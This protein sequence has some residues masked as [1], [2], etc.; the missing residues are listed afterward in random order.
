MQTKLLSKNQVNFDLRYLH[1][2]E[3]HEPIAQYS[4]YPV[5]D[6]HC[7][8]CTT[9]FTRHYLRLTTCQAHVLH[10]KFQT[11]N[12][13]QIQM[14]NRTIHEKMSCLYCFRNEWKHFCTNHVIHSI[15]FNPSK[16]DSIWN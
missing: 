3:L 14:I 13:I 4:R 15:Q 2:Y 1:A 5:Y 10:S 11:S 6:V 16:L 12:D 8:H 7:T 9:H